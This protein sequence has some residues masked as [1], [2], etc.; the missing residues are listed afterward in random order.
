MTADNLS[1]RELGR[2]DR[3]MRL[4]GVGVV[5]QHKLRNASV[6]VVGV[7][8]LGSPVATYLAAAGV[9]RIGLVDFDTVDASN[10]HRSAVHT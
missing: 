9:G 6:L 10:L 4:P 5:G 1:P 2:Y 8:G 3:Q 7:G